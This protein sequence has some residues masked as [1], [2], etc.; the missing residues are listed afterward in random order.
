M[1]FDQQ[2]LVPDHQLE[3]ST[4][5]LCDTLPYQE[6]SDD[7]KTTWKDMSLLPSGPAFAPHCFDI[8][9]TTRLLARMEPAPDKAGAIPARIFIHA[10]SVF[11]FDTEDPRRTCLNP[12][13]PSPEA[14]PI[15]FP[16]VAAYYD[17]LI[18]TMHDP[19]T[20]YLTTKLTMWCRTMA[21]YLTLYNVSR[22]GVAFTPEDE[23]SSPEERELIPE[24]LNVIEQLKAENR[25]W[26]VRHALG[27]RGMDFP[28]SYRERELLRREH[29]EALGTPYVAPQRPRPE[30]Y[31]PFSRGFVMGAEGKQ[32]RLT[33][34]L[35]RSPSGQAYI[36]WVKKLQWASS[37]LKYIR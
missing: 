32:P 26:L 15:L 9:K 3:S 10:A 20:P 37:K 22:R 33:P 31:P 16:T 8:G 27:L 34:Y 11:H 23:D 1:W 19:P 35:R 2:L 6:L 14:A 28:D 24:F 17:A 13:P 5:L 36:D 4:K 12:E 21:G 7:P 25:P 18:D 29:C 30:D